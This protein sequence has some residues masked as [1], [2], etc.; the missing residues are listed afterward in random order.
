MKNSLQRQDLCG[1]LYYRETGRVWEVRMHHMGTSPSS[2]L[3]KREPEETQVGVGG[4]RR[5]WGRNKRK[6]LVTEHD[7]Y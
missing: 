7:G 4:A 3:G 2:A 5:R 6:L 1:G